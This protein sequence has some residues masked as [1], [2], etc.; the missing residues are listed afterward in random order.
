MILE[1]VVMAAIILMGVTDYM[2]IT[3]WMEQSMV[4]MAGYVVAPSSESYVS[5]A[6]KMMTMGHYWWALA[7]FIFLAYLWRR[8]R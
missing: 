5:T 2:G 8:Y 4:S 1:L 6:S 3:S 7:G